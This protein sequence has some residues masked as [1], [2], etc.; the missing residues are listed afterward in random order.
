MSTKSAHWA[1]WP[2]QWLK[3]PPNAEFKEAEE[4]LLRFGIGSPSNQEQSHSA[5][6]EGPP[7]AILSFQDFVE[8]PLRSTSQ[9]HE[10]VSRGRNDG[11]TSGDRGADDG[12]GLAGTQP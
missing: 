2:S 9:R 1:K 12:G 4:G 8:R 10:E 3:T 5:Q 11:E 6:R 7:G